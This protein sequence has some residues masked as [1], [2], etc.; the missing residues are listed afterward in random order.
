MKTF[1]VFTLLLVFL[2]LGAMY[3]HVIT[4]SAG[5]WSMVTIPIEQLATI[6]FNGLQ[7]TAVGVQP[8]YYLDDVFLNP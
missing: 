4:G 6:N 8:T 2:F 7:F 5:A 3:C 1:L